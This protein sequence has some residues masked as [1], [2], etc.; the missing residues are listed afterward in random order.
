MEGK[1]G[2]VKDPSL[3]QDGVKLIEWAARE[4]P[5]LKLIGERFAKEQPLKGLRLAGCLHV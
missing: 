1:K 3:A 2:D 5:V 4:M